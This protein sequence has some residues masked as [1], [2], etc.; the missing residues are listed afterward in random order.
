MGEIRTFLAIELPKKIIDQIRDIQN[1]LRSSVYQVKWVRPEN[2]HLTLKFF[3]NIEE[4]TIEEISRVIKGVA[5]KVDT[6]DLDVRGIGVFPNISRPRVVWVGVE[7][8]DQNLDL[9][10]KEVEV[11]LEKIGFEPEGRK[12]APHL[13]LG[14][15]KSLKDKRRLIDQV[16]MFKG[17]ELGSFNVENLFLFKSDLRPSG[18]VYTKLS[19]FDLGKP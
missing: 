15:V 16:Q 9:L 12:F 1:D 14:R 8:A 13:T 5:S 10:H 19:T 17:C 4:K 2:I 11:T 18:A 6:F 7:S 3:G